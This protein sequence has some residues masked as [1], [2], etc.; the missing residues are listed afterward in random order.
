MHLFVKGAPEIVASLCRPESIPAAYDGVVSGYAQHGYRLI[1]VASRR[2]SISYAKAQKIKR[3]LIECDLNMLG[4]VVME[5]RVKSQTVPVIA[6]LNKARIRT[7]MVTG[8]NVLTAMSVARECGILRPFKVR[9]DLRLTLCS[10]GRS[11]WSTADCWAT[12]G[13]TS[14]CGSRCPPRRSWW[15]RTRAP[16]T[17]TRSRATWWTPTTSWPS[18]GP[19]SRPSARTIPSCSTSWCACATCTRACRPTR[20][21]CWST[22]CRAWATWWPCAGTAP[23]TAQR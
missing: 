6:Q 23:T 15:T 16:P 22:D 8:D 1:A 14:R 2:L 7:V 4:V 9:A 18:A 17:W 5:N 3:E 20:S 13:C 10:R 19:P 12:D 11:C 21:R